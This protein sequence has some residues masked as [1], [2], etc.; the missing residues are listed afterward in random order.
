MH[1]DDPSGLADFYARALGFGVTQLAD[2]V[3]RLSGPDRSLLIAQGPPNGRPCHAYR[4]ESSSQLEEIRRF[5]RDQTLD[6]EAFSSPLF[7][8][9]TVAVRDPDGWLNVFGLPRSD[10]PPDCDPQPAATPPARLQHVVVTS[11]NLPEMIDFYEN[12]LG[13]VASD[14][15]NDDLDDPATRRAAFYRTDPEHHSF[16]IFGA[17][18]IGP[19]HHAYETSCWNDIR[20]WA[21]HM[22]RERIKIWWG[23]GRHGP[24]NNLFFMIRDPHGHSVELSAELEVMPREMPARVWPLDERSLNLWGPG[25]IRE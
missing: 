14:Y 10:M 16:A 15:C 22:S 6:V 24:G 5:L 12:R 23:P 2:G 21:D 4:V 9:D 11:P 20:D 17:S 1:S 18:A 7:E 8:A 13:F 25:W 3:R 19:D